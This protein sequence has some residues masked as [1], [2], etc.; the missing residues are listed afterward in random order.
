MTAS[1]LE[2]KDRTFRGALAKSASHKRG[3]ATRAY[4][5]GE[6]L[7]VD[8]PMPGQRRALADLSQPEMVHAL[9]AVVSPSSGSG[10]VTPP[11]GYG[12]AAPLGTSRRSNQK[13]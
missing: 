6:P 9:D 3:V 5:T 10:P 13:T 7:A 1:A 4:T 8:E 12:A 2:I 11:D